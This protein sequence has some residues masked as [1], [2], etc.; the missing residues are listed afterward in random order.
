MEHYRGVTIQSLEITVTVTQLP[1]KENNM[2]NICR[3]SPNLDD[4]FL[5]PK[6]VFLF[7][8][9]WITFVLRHW[10]DSQATQFWFIP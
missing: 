4:F 8:S 9:I 1:V 3:T 2:Q 7:R 10:T 6:Q 5:I